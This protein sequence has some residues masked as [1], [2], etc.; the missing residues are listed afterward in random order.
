MEAIIQNWLTQFISI[1]GIIYLYG[2]AVWGLNRLFYNMLGG[3]AHGICVATGFVGTPVHELGHAIFCL[4]FLHRI[5]EIKLFTPNSK[6]GVLGYVNHSYNKKNVY[7]QIGNFFIGVGPILFG[8]AVLFLLMYFLSP[9]MFRAIT[10]GIGKGSELS[11]STVIGAGTD[12]LSAMFRG[13]DFT[14][15]KQWLFFI[16]AVLITLHMSL[17]PAD[18]KGSVA[19]TGYIAALLLAA[20]VVLYFVHVKAFSMAKLTA[21]CVDIGLAI[22]GFLTFA[23]LVAAIVALI[24]VIIKTVFS[25]L[26]R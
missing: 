7:H 15:G 21:Y 6:D 14:S 4:L 20:N 16:L 25:I 24:G 19:G 13:S 8:S 17:S 9:D 11:V 3:R 22:A 12:M 1:V 18:M 23:V 5:N 26:G 10:G 2:F